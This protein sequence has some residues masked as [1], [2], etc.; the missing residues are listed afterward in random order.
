MSRAAGSVRRMAPRFALCAW[1]MEMS[2]TVTA[3]AECDEILLGIISEPATGVDVVDLKISQR[4]VV[5]AA[6]SIAG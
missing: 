3:R 4:A 5:L 1:K 2:G 6:A